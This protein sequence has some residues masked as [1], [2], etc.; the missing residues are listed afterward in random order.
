MHREIAPFHY[1]TQDLPQ[2]T[3]E[4]QVLIAC[5]AGVKWI[6]LR[7]KKSGFNE[8][9]QA[10]RVARKITLDWGVVLIINDNV[11]IAGE[12]NADGVHLG[13]NDIHWT[14]AR[15]LLGEEKIIG[16]SAHSFEDVSDA[17]NAEV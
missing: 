15:K 7:L 11:E 3:H 5:R 8:W 4:E 17:R 14:E 1:L 9:A 13:K 10:A 16:L 2:R 6:Q 12:V